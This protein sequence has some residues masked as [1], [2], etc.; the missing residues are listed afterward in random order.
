MSSRPCGPVLPSSIGSLGRG[1]ASLDVR[2][3]ILSYSA[4]SHASARVV[5]ARCRHVCGRKLD[6]DTPGL[7][8]RQFGPNTGLE[9]QFHEPSGNEA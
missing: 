3:S 8:L 9:A 5:G 2:R 1:V 6:P 4:P 7:W